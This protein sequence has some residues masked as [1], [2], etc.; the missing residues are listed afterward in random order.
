MMLPELRPDSCFVVQV[1]RPQETGEMLAWRPD[2]LGHMCCLDEQLTASLRASRIPL[3]LCLSS[4]VITE[5]VTG[6]PDHHF[7]QLYH[8][9]I[10]FCLRILEP[11]GSQC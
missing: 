11:P 9:G 2:R 5:S 4:N 3:E 8:A 10:L 7:G 6:Y 1:Y